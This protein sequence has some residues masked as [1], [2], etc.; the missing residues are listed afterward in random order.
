MLPKVS[1]GVIPDT[2]CRLDQKWLHSY[3]FDTILDIGANI[4]RFAVTADA[5]F[6]AATIYAFEP[7]PKCYDKTAAIINTIGK[8]KAFN[9]G[10]GV[11][12]E[13]IPINQNEF[14]PSSSFLPMNKTHV[15]AFPFTEKQT[16]TLVQVRRLDD[17]ADELCLGSRIL[18]KIDVQGY[19]RDVIAG[20]KNTIEKAKVV[21]IELSYEEL[22][23][24]QP[25][26]GEV[27]D[28]LRSLGFRFAGT[29]AQMPHPKDGRL[30]DADC[31]FVKD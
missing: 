18:I 11:K 16:Q 6:P 20:G 15:D 7:L 26:F 9:F 31:L 21:L 17:V 28:A 12:S 10:L 24:G 3:K 30:L 25:L 13:T 2:Y 8:G 22:Y 27:Y 29:L 5:V 14:S 1:I 23:S 4:G 19:E